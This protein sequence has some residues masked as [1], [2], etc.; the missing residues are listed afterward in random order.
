MKI[1]KMEEVTR[2]YCDVCATDITANNT[3]PGGATAKYNFQVCNGRRFDIDTIKNEKG[4]RLGCEHLALLYTEYPVLA[5]ANFQK[6]IDETDNTETSKTC[7][8]IFDDSYHNSCPEHGVEIKPS[9]VYDQIVGG[10]KM[11]RVMELYNA[12]QHNHDQIAKLTNLYHA[13]VTKIISWHNNVN[14]KNDNDG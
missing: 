2:V 9:Q 3:G 10:D 12:G 6:L 11:A 14:R 7:T 8:C 4:V 13:T 5:N 1:T